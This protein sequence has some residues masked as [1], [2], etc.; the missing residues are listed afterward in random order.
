MGTTFEKQHI[1]SQLDNDL[2]AHYD[3]LVQ[4][5]K[6]NEFK[7]Y[8]S[9]LSIEAFNQKEFNRRVDVIFNALHGKEGE[10]GK[11]QSFFEY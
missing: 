6:A 9:G 5:D 3:S 7:K 4:E 11:A 10:D 1:S 8:V 2:E